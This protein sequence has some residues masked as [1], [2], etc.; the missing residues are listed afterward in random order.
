MG[1]SSN[2]SDQFEQRVAAARRFVESLDQIDGEKDRRLA[3]ILMALDAGLRNPGTGAEFEAYVMLE[4]VV[5]G[6]T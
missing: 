5:K 4:D 6:N 3:T 1:T 2:S